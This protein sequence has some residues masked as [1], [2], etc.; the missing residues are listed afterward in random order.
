MSSTLDLGYVHSLLAGLCGSCG[1]G[2]LI[3]AVRVVSILLH[4]GGS[5]LGSSEG[6]QRAG[7]AS[8]FY[9]ASPVFSSPISNPFLWSRLLATCSRLTS[10]AL[11]QPDYIIYLLP[12]LYFYPLS[13]ITFLPLLLSGIDPTPLSVTS[14][15]PPLRTIPRQYLVREE[16][17]Q[18]KTRSG[19]CC[20]CE[21]FCG[22]FFLLFRQTYLPTFPSALP[23]SFYATRHVAPLT[24]SPTST[25]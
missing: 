13:K 16:K 23:R 22:V 7:S 4:F 8:T 6:I 17:Y 19:T 20:L 9:C 1:P 3:P 10:Q 2:S 21:Y 15:R 14:T 12:T 24:L 5:I 11:S 18:Y 25:P